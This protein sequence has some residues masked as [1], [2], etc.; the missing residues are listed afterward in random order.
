[1]KKK[2]TFNLKVTTFALM[3]VLTNLSYAQ[4]VYDVIAGS[5]NHTSLTAVIN[6]AGLDVV[7]QDGT[8]TYTVFA[9][10]NNAIDDVAAALGVTVPDLLMLPQADLAYILTYHVLDVEVPSSGVTNGLIA[11]PLNTDNTLKFTVDGTDVFVNHAQ[12]NAPDLAATNGVVHSIDAVV[13]VDETVADIAIDSPNHTVLVQ[14]VVEA[15]LLPDLTNPFAQL[16]VFAPTDVAF[17]SALGA[18]GISAGDLLASPEL[19]NILL[20][21]VLG[22]EVVS[23]DLSNGQLAQPLNMA[24][25]LKITID[26]MD[27]F[28]NQ[29]QVTGANIFADNGV[30]HV[31]DAVVLPNETVADIAIDSPDHTT[32]V[33]AVVEAR[34]LPA[35]TDPF[36]EFT[37]FAPDNDAFDALATDLSTDLA[38]I[39]AL[40]NL[41]DILLYHVASGELLSG[42]LTNGSLTML[43]S[44]SVVIDLS[45]G[46]MVNSSTV[47]A[48]NLTSDNGVVHV[49]D[50]VL[51]E[52]TSDIE[53]IAAD[54]IEI[55][56]N[57]SS[58]F[59]TIN[60]AEG[61]FNSLA[62][63]DGQ[64]RKVLETSLDSDSTTID[65][66]HLND[67]FYTITFEGSNEI[68]SRRFLISSNK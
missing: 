22:A 32:L 41:S 24:N 19:A 68:V 36:D 49:I 23:G 26:G 30:V 28:V 65:V 29:A 37:V 59:I 13:L 43:N 54:L 40:P 3:M 63:I 5:P 47:T 21:H 38:G 51:I 9:P 46:V 7:L 66:Q 52:N 55:F 6:A 2:I 57:P 61:N 42:D 14:A 50:Q 4:T 53:S 15:R 44:G 25:T 67:G 39:L 48:P 12:V 16:T 62:I 31:L 1:M 60:G 11:T 10:D 17:T 64:G 45:S 35:L 18:L 27:V 58:D 33:A 20:Y 34:L 8:A 56:P